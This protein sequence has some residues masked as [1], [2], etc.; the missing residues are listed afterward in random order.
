MGKVCRLILLALAA[1]CLVDAQ[2]TRIRDTLYTPFD[3]KLFEGTITIQGP[4]MR[5]ADGRTIVRWTGVLTIVNGDLDIRLEPN[6]TAQ[7]PGTSYTVTYRPKSGTGWTEYWVVPTSSEPVRVASV[8]VAQPPTPQL[9]IQPSQIAS[10]DATN[11]QVLTWSASLNRWVPQTVTINASQ[12]TAGTLS[13]T[14]GGTNQSTWVAGTCVQVSADGTRLESASGP[15]GTGSGGVG[16]SGNAGSIAM[17]TDS[18][19]LGNSV[20]T[21]GQ[22]AVTI[23][24]NLVVAGGIESQSSEAGAVVLY[25]ASGGSVTIQAPD[26]SSSFTLTAPA[27][28]ATLA[29]EGHEHDAS[30]I[31]SG[32]LSVA[33]GGT[34]STAFTGGRCIQSSAD[35]QSLTVASGACAVD[36]HSHTL[37]GDVTGDVGSTTV[38]RIR[39]RNVSSAAPSDGQALVWS[40]AESQWKPGSVSGGG[41]DP[42]DDT[43]LWFREDFPTVSTSSHQI[44]A[45]GWSSSCASGTISVVSRTGASPFKKV[46]RLE[47]GATS[48]NICHVALGSSGTSATVL[49]A[50]GSY[51]SWDS[52]FHLRNNSA[53]STGMV[54]FVGYIAGGSNTPSGGSSTARIGIEYDTSRGDTS[55][56]FVSCNGSNCTRQSSGVSLDTAWHRLRVRSQTA[57]TI[58]FALDGG[59]EV[60]INT[61]VP[62]NALAPMFGVRAEEN[63]AKRVEVDR[64]YWSGPNAQ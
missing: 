55:F 43:T 26:T 12:V 28:N 14:R 39:G 4:S 19:T 8:R 24:K 58:L 48:G 17:W 11:G 63:A 35:G 21:Q 42:L 16:G 41:F 46:Y 9:T 37:A 61:N 10:G 6:D 57:G 54:L 40:A 18:T 59:T 38:A 31:S 34:G 27:A 52:I 29:V 13:L 3:G 49:G 25:S 47:T 7:P 33:R 30:A 64:W 51:G 32:I 50:L 62:T 60:S 23:A 2:G 45:Y 20:I 15:C 1:S 56:M 53:A 44:G 5:T 22:D 36:G